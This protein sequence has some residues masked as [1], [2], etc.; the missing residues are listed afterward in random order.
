[1]IAILAASAGAA[2]GLIACDRNRRPVEPER[3]WSVS[4]RNLHN[5]YVDGS[6]RYTDRTVVVALPPFSYILADG[7][8][9]WHGGDP[10]LPPDIIFVCQKVPPDATQ[11][12]EVQ[13]VCRGRFEYRPLHPVGPRF[14]VRVDGATWAP[15]H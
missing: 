14:H 15:H 11:V 4:A 7:V 1:M 12:I 10:K 2:I 6:D 8:I 5:S 13:G 3:V 9:Q